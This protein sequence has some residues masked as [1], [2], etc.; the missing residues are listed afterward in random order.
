MMYYIPIWFQAVKGASAVKSGIMN[1]PLLLTV[2]VVSILVGAAVTIFGYYT[3]YMIIGAAIQAVGYGVMSTFRP[4]SGPSVW[5]G[6]Q[7]LTGVGVG[8]AM[9]QPMIAV[10][11][12]LDIKDVPIGTSL[13]VFLQTLGGSLFTSVGQN[14]FSNKLIMYTAQYAPGLDPSIVL[15]TGATEI[16]SKIP[17]EYLAGVTLAYNDALDQAFLVAAIIGSLSII[18]A[19]FVEWKS[20]KGKKLGAGAA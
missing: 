8:L 17:A 2:T 11:V 9:Q 16:Q 18:P 1:L 6:Y 14:I 13:V 7:V 5:I 10:Q 20:V 12:V 4:D 3:P 15:T 19:L